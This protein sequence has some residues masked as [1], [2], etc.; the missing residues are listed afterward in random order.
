MS[1]YFGS[2][3]HIQK[4]LAKITDTENIVHILIEGSGINFIDLAGSEMLVAENK[5][6]AKHGGGLY[7]VGM[8]P[9]VYADA[10]KSHFIK[11]IGNDHFFDSKSQAIRRIK[12]RLDEDKCSRCQLK[13]FNECN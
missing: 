5:R 1:I 7:F 9:G 2:V 4:K 10:A 8:K 11:M 3:N 13:I 12:R 6:L